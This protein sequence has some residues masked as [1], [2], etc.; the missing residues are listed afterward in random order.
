MVEMLS[1]MLNKLWLI[2]VFHDSLKLSTKFIFIIKIKTLSRFDV[3][4][5]YGINLSI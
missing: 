3:I 2:D 4:L 1:L 5:N